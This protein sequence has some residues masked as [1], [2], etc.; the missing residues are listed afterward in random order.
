MIREKNIYGIPQCLAKAETSS[1]S[2]L[3]SFIILIFNYF[4]VIF[5]EFCL[6]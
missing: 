5:I 6:F 2:V 4:N 3:Y 1:S